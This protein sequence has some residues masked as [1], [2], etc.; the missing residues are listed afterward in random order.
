MN[1][2]R[3]HYVLELLELSQIYFSPGLSR[4]KCYNL[5]WSNGFHLKGD[6]ET[7][8]NLVAF[9]GKESIK[10]ESLAQVFSCEFCDISKKAFF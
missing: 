5:V 9:Y 8:W 4:V 2:I 6:S 1:R 7:P 10:E 3:S